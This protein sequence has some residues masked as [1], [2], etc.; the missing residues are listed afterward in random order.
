MRGSCPRTGESGISDLQSVVT[1]FIYHTPCILVPSCKIHSGNWYCDKSG[2]LNDSIDEN[3]G[4]KT[5]RAI[6]D[7][8]GY[9]HYLN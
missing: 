6:D 4:T 5:P 2:L 1:P 9:L 7:R 3:K 8:R